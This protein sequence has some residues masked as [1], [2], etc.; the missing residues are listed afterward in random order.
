MNDDYFDMAEALLTALRV[1]KPQGA[2]DDLLANV[3]RKSVRWN[4]DVE[5]F[6]DIVRDTAIEMD[7][8]EDND[9]WHT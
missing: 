7:L 5:E 9:A 8:I 1:A 6:Y 3:L 2:E 4:I